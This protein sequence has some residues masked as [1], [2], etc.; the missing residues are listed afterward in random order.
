MLTASEDNNR[1]KTHKN[2]Q[3]HSST[4]QRYDDIIAFSCPNGDCFTS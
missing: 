1:D 2:S 4:A 3:T